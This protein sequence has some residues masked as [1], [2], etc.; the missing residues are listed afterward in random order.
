MRANKLQKIW[1]SFRI[2][3]TTLK[4][5]LWLLILAIFNKCSRTKVDAHVRGWAHKLL[6][7]VR[8]EYKVFNPHNV[9]FSPKQCYIVMSNHRSHFDI[10][11]I[12]AAFPHGSIRMI[13]KKELFKVPVFGRAMKQ[14]EFF[15]IDRENAKQAQQDLKLARTKMLGGLVPWVAPEGTRSLDGKLQKFKKGGFLLALETQATIVPVVICGS[16]KILP[17]KK[18][19]FGIGEKVTIHIAE[20]VDTS[21]YTIK[22]I[23]QLMALVNDR[24]CKI[25]EFCL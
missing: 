6:R 18:L 22:D 5:S 11:L 12:F 19:D 15:S 21:L 1:I 8:A 17:A 20:P 13:A 3:L 23:R 24:I 14:S 7:I 16:E 2:V 9:I 25:S 4:T 10:P